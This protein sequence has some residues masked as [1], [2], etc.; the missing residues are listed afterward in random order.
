MLGAVA[1]KLF[2][3]A[4]DRRIKS[5]QTRVSAINALEKELQGLSDDMLSRNAKAGMPLN[6]DRAEHRNEH[7]DEI[8][9]VLRGK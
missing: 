4:N 2:G 6:V 3:S 8:E 7:L 9:H 5:Y 1:R